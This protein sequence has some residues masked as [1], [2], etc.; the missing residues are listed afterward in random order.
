MSRFQ[1]ALERVGYTNTHTSDLSDYAGE[2]DRD[3]IGTWCSSRTCGHSSSLR[4]ALV[5]ITVVRACPRCAAKNYL[6]Y[7]SISKSQRDLFDKRARCTR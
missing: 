7:D 3:P 6:L 1:S 4:G 5:A 2:I